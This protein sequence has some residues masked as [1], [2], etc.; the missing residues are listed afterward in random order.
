[1]KPYE[2]FRAY[3][4]PRDR[5]FRLILRKFKG[6]PIRV[7]QIGGIQNWRPDYRVHSGWSDFFWAEYI[8]RN[9]GELILCDINQEALDNSREA[10]EAVT[11]Q[12]DMQFYPFLLKGELYLKDALEKEE[13]FDIYYLDGSDDPNEMFEQFS[14]ITK[15]SGTVIICDDWKIKGTVL[16]QTIAPSNKYDFETYSAANGVAVFSYH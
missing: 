9:G 7:F 12:S 6:Q 16:A 8:K 15:R 13:K 1:M 3:P 4:G 2:I 14:L 5:I 10:F 11:G